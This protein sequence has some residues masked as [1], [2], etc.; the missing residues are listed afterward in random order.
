MTA[1]MLPALAQDRVFLHQPMAHAIHL[2]V[3]A[4]SGDRS[5]SVASDA[6][7]LGCQP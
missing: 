2:D 7:C 3:N 5:Q 6:E 1:E 4:E